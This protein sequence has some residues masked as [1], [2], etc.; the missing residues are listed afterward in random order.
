MNTA[1]LDWF[2]EEYVFRQLCGDA[3]SQAQDEHSQEF[4][5]QMVIAAKQTGLTTPLS[6]RQ[7]VWLCKLA[8]WELPARRPDS[9]LQDFEPHRD[10]DE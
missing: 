4:A 8:D 2:E 10:R 9:R 7:L 3:Q 5:A 1:A 6:H